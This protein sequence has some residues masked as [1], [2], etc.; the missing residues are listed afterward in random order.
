MNRAAQPKLS[1]RVS[2]ESLR[3][4]HLPAWV[5]SDRLASISQALPNGPWIIAP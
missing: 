3:E 1:A 2:D 5:G 4:I